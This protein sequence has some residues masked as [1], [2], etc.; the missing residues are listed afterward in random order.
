MLLIGDNGA[1]ISRYGD[2]R[3]GSYD[4]K[5]KFPCDFLGIISE[6]VPGLNDLAICGGVFGIINQSTE[7]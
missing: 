4:L 5:P 3:L 2:M 7:W 6:V 1:E